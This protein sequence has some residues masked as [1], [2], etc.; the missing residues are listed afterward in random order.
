[1]WKQSRQYSIAPVLATIT[2]L[3]HKG[4]YDSRLATL[5]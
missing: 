2:V 5:A 3:N 4:R 1:M